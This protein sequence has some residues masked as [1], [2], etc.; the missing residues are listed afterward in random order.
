MWLQLVISEIP[1]NNNL[2]ILIM[3]FFR[4]GQTSI[5]KENTGNTTANAKQICPNQIT[6][7]SAIMQFYVK[8]IN[9]ETLVK[10]FAQLHTLHSKQS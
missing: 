3:V 5:I 2:K 1:L 10:Y 4:R 6:A 7:K 8:C 9:Y